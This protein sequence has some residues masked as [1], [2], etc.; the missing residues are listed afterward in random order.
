MPTLQRGQEAEF[1]I[2][3]AGYVSVDATGGGIAEIAI[4]AGLPA[5][6]LR[7]IAGEVVT[8]D[9]LPAGALITVSCVQGVVGYAENAAAPSPGGA[10]AVT[11]ASLA[12]TLED[13]A[14]TDPASLAR[15]QAS[16]SGYRMYFGTYAEIMAISANPGDEAIA[17]DLGTAGLSLR[18]NGGWKIIGTQQVIYS[19]ALV[20]GAPVVGEQVIKSLALPAGLLLL[21][22]LWRVKVLFSK[23]NTTS[24]AIPRT[25][26][27]ATGTVADAQVSGNSNFSSSG[28]A[29]AGMLEIVFPTATTFRSAGNPITGVIPW[30]W[31]QNTQPI[32][33]SGCASIT[34]ALYLSATLDVAAAGC[35][36]EVST[37]ILEAVA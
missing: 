27:G 7:R 5:G 9:G 28:R 24:S 32:S 11:A 18:W 15:I 13:A 29:F 26:L 22:P 25:R 16:V 17:S 19:S 4:P 2:A 35:T 10:G 34:G 33:S 37:F 31:A 1:R 12:G 36:P 30:P 14:T 20:A 8:F 6:P 3:S 21:A 23:N